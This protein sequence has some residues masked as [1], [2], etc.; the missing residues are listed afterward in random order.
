MENIQWYPGHMTK[1][2]RQVAA[3]LE[4]VD[5]AVELVDARA[6]ISSRNPDID[7]ILGEK[8]RVVLLNK[9]DLAEQV[10]TQNFVSYFTEQG[11]QALAVE[12]TTG[13]GLN[14]FAPT[15]ERALTA[16]K[17]R[18]RQRGMRP[19]PYRIMVLGI[20][21]VGKSSLIN[22][23]AGRKKTVT[24]NRPGVTRGP[25]WV[26]VQGMDLLDTPGIL[27]PKFE[28]PET[29]MKL[30]AIGAI[31]DLVVE[32]PVIA[33]AIMHF[34]VH[35]QPQKLVERYG[36]LPCIE[37]YIK[38]KEAEEPPFINSIES[39]RNE[40]I[41]ELLYAVG[42]QRGFL[43]KGGQV[44]LL[45]SATQLLNDFRQGRLGRFTLDF[46]PEKQ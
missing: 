7:K 23:L 31:S 3:D 42:Q 44:D 28:D 26:R 21:N 45:K 1:A 17:E 30:S 10:E 39:S 35:R 11:F 32:M 27:W 5:L 41:L 13:N 38:N 12:A 19:R 2:R 18:W 25:Q 8:P 29:G 15:V 43:V 40:E 9:V 24:A 22:R 6:P 34:L 46:V 4:K 36:E 16:L 37:K 14:R 20:P 33:G